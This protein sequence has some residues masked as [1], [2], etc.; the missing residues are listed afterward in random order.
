MRN[1]V[2]LVLPFFT[3]GMPMP[4]Y[5]NLFFETVAHNPEL[6]LLV[7]SDC[8]WYEPRSINVTYVA[9]TLSDVRERAQA[10]FNFKVSMDTPYKLC[11]YKPAYG[12]MFADYLGGYDFWGN[13]DLDM[14]FG[15]FNRFVTDT[16]LDSYD[17][18]YQHGHLTLY[19]NLDVVNREF[20]SDYGM[21]Y[22]KVLTTPISCVFDELEGVQKKFDHD[23]LRT[24]KGFDFLDINPWRWHLS[25]AHSG[26]PQ[27]M[28]GPE[29]GFD[30]EHECFSWDDGHLW[31]HAIAGGG[32]S[33]RT[34]F[35][36]STSRRGGSRRLRK[37]SDPEASGLPIM[38]VMRRLDL[39][40][41]MT[42]TSTTCSRRC[43][44]SKQGLRTSV[45]FGAGG[46]TSTFC[47]DKCA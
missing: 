17:K 45:L 10:L 46:S 39:Q 2:C 3:G 7:L 6:D 20:M 14:A 30:Y 44:R 31:R 43:G 13:C 47:T 26:V 9:C 35:C 40:V 15:N 42:S 19:R 22:R 18:V 27:E 12:L 16:V 24:Y 41:L 32:V 29:S 4:S 34:S 21:D 28:L 38:G 33:L 1:R 8:G 11:D 36:I 5:A 23:G 37:P 25:R